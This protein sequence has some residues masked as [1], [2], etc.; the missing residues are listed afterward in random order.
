MQ[1]WIVTGGA[2]SGKSLFCEVVK[3]LN[4]EVEVFSSDELVRKKL[5]DTTFA[6]QIGELFGPEVIQGD[7][8]IDRPR[9]RDL[10]FEDSAAREKL[11]ALLH[12]EVFRQMESD[13]EAA[14]NRGVNLFLAEVPLFFESG[15]KVRPDRTV[16]VAAPVQLQSHRITTKRGLTDQAAARIILAQ[17]PL[18][19]KL[20][21][22]DVVVWNE[23]DQ[24]LLEMQA[25]HLLQ[26]LSSHHVH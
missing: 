6:P 22:A 26:Q 14:Q 12:P 20:A 25:R 7:G 18:E 5:E 3:R 8:K 23:G 1:F 21:L 24:R 4:A 13:R 9:L 2:G 11:E 16:L 10:V 15:G 17:L 19:R